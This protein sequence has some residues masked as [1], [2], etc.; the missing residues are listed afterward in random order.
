MFILLHTLYSIVATYLPC[1]LY[2]HVVTELSKILE[3]TGPYYFLFIFI[4]YLIL[5]F[6][7]V[8]LNELKVDSLQNYGP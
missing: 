1:M 4:V 6:A 7:V 2:T 5:N 8:I 3:Q